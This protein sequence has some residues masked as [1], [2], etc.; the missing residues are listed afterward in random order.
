MLVMN[1]HLG[2]GEELGRFCGNE[3]P[4]TTTSIGNEMTV[5]FRSDQTSSSIGF[6]AQY[7]IGLKFVSNFF[8]VGCNT[9]VVH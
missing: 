8:V 3:Q 1:G 7:S 9:S 5:R 2:D 4:P 6:L